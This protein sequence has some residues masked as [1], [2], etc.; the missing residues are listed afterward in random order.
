M[1][2]DAITNKINSFFSAMDAKITSVIPMPAILLICAAMSKKG[3][4]PVR[5]LTNV[6]Q[7]LEASGIP[8]GPNPDG[9]PNLIVAASHAILNEVFR[10]MT[11]DA[12]VQGGIKPGEMMVMSQGSN[13]A[14]VVVSTG[15]NLTPTFLVGNIY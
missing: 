13:S 7:A 1:S 10:A 5:S 14:G 3:L 8:T 11:E 15:S 9:T 6:C 2:I 12:V 4:S